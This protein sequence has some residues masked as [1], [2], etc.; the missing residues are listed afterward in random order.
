[1]IKLNNE[2]YDLSIAGLRKALH[3]EINTLFWDQEGEYITEEMEEELREAHDMISAQDEDGL[4]GFIIDGVDMDGNIHFEKVSEDAY[5][6]EALK[7]AGYGVEKSNVSRSLYVINDEGEEVRIADHKRPSAP[8]VG[9]NYVEH[10]Y[11]NELI[12]ENNQVTAEELSRY[13]I[14]LEKG[15]YILG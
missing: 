4:D 7:E 6:E 12:V 3:E 13:S 8:T 10:Q 11:D 15:E 1:M 5:L 14:E 9:G 2:L